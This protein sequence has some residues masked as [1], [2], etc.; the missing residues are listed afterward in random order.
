M[1]GERRLSFPKGKGRKVMMKYKVNHQKKL[2][3]Q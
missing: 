2:I 1:G 3:L